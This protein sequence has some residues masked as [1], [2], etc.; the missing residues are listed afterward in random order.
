M[1]AG[2]EAQSCLRDTVQHSANGGR[3]PA[4]RHCSGELPRARRLFA[5][6]HKIHGTLAETYLRDRGITA[7]HNIGA[8]RFHP[9]C[10]YCAD[11]GSTAET[12]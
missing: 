2:A 5:M 10:Y 4:A 8:L 9:R 6:A 3:R 1:G 12:R 7:L 11:Y